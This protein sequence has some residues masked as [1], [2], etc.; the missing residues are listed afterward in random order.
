MQEYY[1]QSKPIG[2]DV[3]EYIRSH[4]S[5]NHSTGIIS[6]N[7]RAN[8]NGSYDKDGYLILKIKKKQ[9]KAHRVAWFLYYGVFPTKE[10]DH[11]NRNRSDNRI[12]NL[13]EVFREGNLLNTTRKPNP[14][15]GVI[16]VYYD[17]CTNGLKKR[18]TTRYGGSTFRFM[19]LEEAVLF[20]KERNLSV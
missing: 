10:I 15:T 1:N 20:R 11:I 12:V 7:D 19:T 13:R 16:G 3:L 6:R 4:F 5:Y 17:T 9:Y 8:S 18:F 14:K 2:D